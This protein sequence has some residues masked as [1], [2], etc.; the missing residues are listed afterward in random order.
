M[1]ERDAIM[2]ML[3]QISWTVMIHISDYL[4]V[5][6]GIAIFKFYTLHFADADSW[7]NV[8]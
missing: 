8:V 5:H 3:P 1:V 2:D 4:I 7:N 6:C